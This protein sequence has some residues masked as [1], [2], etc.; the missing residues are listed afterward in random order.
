MAGSLY[1]LLEENHLAYPTLHNNA[2][3]MAEYAV[4]LQQTCEIDNY[5]GAFLHDRGGRGFRSR[6]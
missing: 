5:G 2:A 3:A 1:A 4:L 6:G